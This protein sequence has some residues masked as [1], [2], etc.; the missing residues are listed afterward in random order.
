MHLNKSVILICGFLLFAR[1][2][3][4]QEKY[5]R[6]KIPLLSSTIRDFVLN[7]LNLD[8]FHQEDSTVTVVLNR[9]EMSRLLQSGYS[10]ELITEDVVQQTINDNRYASP[11]NNVAQFQSTTCQQ[12]A[13]II[14]VPASFGTG[15]SL[16]LGAA[17]GNSGY[18]TYAE[19][20]SK[21]QTMQIAYPSLV[22]VFT[23]GN[24]AN[25][26]AIYGVKISDNVTVDE[27]E[28]E[29]L[30]TGLQHAREAIGGTSLIFFLQFLGENYNTDPRVKALVD[31]RAIYI[32][33]CVNPDGYMYNYSGASASYPVT[34]GGLWRKNRRNTGGGHPISGLTLTG[35]MGSTGGIVRVQPAVAGQM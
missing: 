11:L 15:G 7:R 8:H 26:N 3:S 25:G 20:I 9:E 14:S 32:I 16:R 13:D 18:F 33:P 5:S 34:G 28:S 12:L 24:S 29:V 31:H 27:G 17:P 23:I 10:Y 1:M 30:Y 35:I 2:V 6:V 4:A 22:Q 21:M 19:M